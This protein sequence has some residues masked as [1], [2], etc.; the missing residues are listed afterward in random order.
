M[1]SA[2]YALELSYWQQSI[3]R[4][5]GVLAA[6]LLPAGTFVYVFLFKMVSFMQ[7]RLG[8]MEAGPYGSMQLL[9]EVGKHLQKED[10][11]PDAADRSLFK[12]A[13]YFVVGAVLLTKFLAIAG[14][15]FFLADLFGKWAAD[16]VL[17]VAASSLVFIFLGMFLDPL[18]IKLLTLP[19]LIPMF[20]ALGLDL[21]WF[22]ILVVKYVEIG[23][24]TPPVGFNV[25]VIKS[26]VGDTVPLETIFRGVTWFLGCEVIILTLL[27][28]FPQ[29]SLY[30]PGL[31]E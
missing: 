20:E 15:P 10:L 1:S 25:Y 22:G 31:I 17:L 11:I 3:L 12:M 14:T 21:I 5:V 23:L 26:V 29:I 28:G 13:P 4:S 16:P 24:I 18:G 7:S 27:I 2:L 9:A 6:V 30:L 19:I 8:P